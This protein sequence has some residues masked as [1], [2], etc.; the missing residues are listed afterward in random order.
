VKI[1]WNPVEIEDMKHYVIHYSDTEPT[2][3]I[4][5][6]SIVVDKNETSLTVTGLDPEKT[7]YFAGSVTDIENFSSWY[8]EV[9]YG[10]QVTAVE[11]ETQPIKYELV[12][13]Y[14]N[15]FNPTTTIKYRIPEN[16]QVTIKLFD[17]LGN[18]IKTLVNENQQAGTHN[19]L[20]DGTDLSSGV[21]FYQITSGN[22]H[23][24]KKCVL[25]K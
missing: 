22:F 13:N 20:L 10:D 8:T 14:P 15:P 17:I 21:Y 3:Y 25:L 16:S 2:D 12:Q 11:N 18:H 4:F 23:A 5:P 7:Y 24:V 9:L 1:A 19:L 6:H